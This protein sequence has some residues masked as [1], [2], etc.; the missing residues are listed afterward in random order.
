MTSIS[1]LST[2]KSPPLPYCPLTKIFDCNERLHRFVW[3]SYNAAGQC[4]TKFQTIPLGTVFPFFRLFISPFFPLLSRMFLE[5]L[6]RLF[7]GCIFGR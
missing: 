1:Y 4:C 2:K 3:P 6:F 5:T 7:V